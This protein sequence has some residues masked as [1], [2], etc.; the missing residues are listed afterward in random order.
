MVAKVPSRFD[1]FCFLSGSDAHDEH[2]S[3]RS[4]LT[5]DV[6]RRRCSLLAGLLHIAGPG[7]GPVQRHHVAAHLNEA[8]HP[9]EGRTYSLQSLPA[10]GL[11]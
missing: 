4:E 8:L 1:T 10:V 11:I 9:E 3:Q 5:A 7:Q 6:R 2:D